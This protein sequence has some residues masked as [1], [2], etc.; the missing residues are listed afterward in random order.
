MW[1]MM[2][3]DKPEDYVVATGITTSV[4][5]FV[6]L[7]FAEAG[8]EIEF[9]GQ[10]INEKGVIKK[11]NHKEYQLVEGSE[12]VNIDPRYFRPTEV[13]LLIGDASKAKSQLGWTPT[14]TL[15]N[16]VSEMVLADIDLCKKD[17]M[18]MSGGFSI[19]R[20]IEH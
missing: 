2:Q 10:G 17:K 5:E 7:A 6:R 14:Y 16:L 13:D 8:I 4:R 9:R 11:T 15:A 12:V 18:L 1:L 20:S 19:K 3:Q